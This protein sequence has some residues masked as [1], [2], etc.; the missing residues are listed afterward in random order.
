MQYRPFGRT[1]LRVSEV[2]FGCWTVSTNWWPDAPR[3]EEGRVRLLRQAYEYGINYFDTADTYGDGMGEEILA[4]AFAGMRDRIVIGTKVGYDWYNHPDRRGQQERP[5][6]WDPQFLRWAVEQSLRRL[7]TDYIDLLQ[8]HNIKNPDVQ[9]DDIWELLERLKEEGKIR[10][11]GVALGPA[12][13]WQEEGEYALLQ[14]RCHAVMMIYNALEQDP[15]RALIRA[16]GEVGAGLQVRVPHSSGMLEGKFTAETRF[17]KGDHRQHRRR[18]WL[19]NGL[20]KI[21]LLKPLFADT[22]M[23]LGQFALKFILKSPEV[24][25]TLPNIYGE[26]QLKEFCAAPDFPDLTDEAFAAVNRLYDENFGLPR[27]A[28]G[29]V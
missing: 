20:K 1:D 16:A 25:T 24:A 2:G 8:Y 14:R 28:Y 4:R 23:T 13:G 21:E 11:Y 17:E 15:G 27:P 7:N 29:L 10:Y 12:I 6:N 26:E 19:E 22:G 9:R 3:D 5:H 18:E